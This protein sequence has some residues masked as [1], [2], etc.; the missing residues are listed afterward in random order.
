MAAHGWIATMANWPAAGGRHSQGDRLVG[1]CWRW[2]SF[3][4]ARTRFGNW[5]F[6]VGGDAKRRQERCVPVSGSRRRCSCHRF[7]AACLFAVLQVADVGSAAAD[8]GLQRNSKPSLLPSSAA[9]C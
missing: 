6:A 3:V 9:P 2:A 4:L 8:R 5:I 1:W 7:S